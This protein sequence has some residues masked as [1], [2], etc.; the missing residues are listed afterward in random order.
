MGAKRNPGL[1]CCAR[2]TRIALRSIRAS[3]TGLD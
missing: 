2:E 3:V 1:L